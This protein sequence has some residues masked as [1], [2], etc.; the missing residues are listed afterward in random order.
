M[1]NNILFQHTF[2]PT[3]SEGQL[4]A[5][6]PS[7]PGSQQIFPGQGGAT[8][9][10]AIYDPSQFAPPVPFQNQVDPH[11]ARRP[12]T[13]PGPQQ[14]QKCQRLFN[15]R[16]ERDRHLRSYLP[17]W[18][19]CPFPHC[20]WRGDR[21]DIFKRHWGD[22][23]GVEGAVPVRWQFEI[24]SPDEVVEFINLGV[25][26]VD[27]A[28]VYARSLVDARMWELGKKDVWGRDSWG[29]KERKAGTYF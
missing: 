17:H 21:I 2:H 23:H 16:Q 20:P 26:S 8:T 4:V 5:R 14:C 29:R 11:S 24:Y 25:L 18:I 19:Y 13:R 9:G 1:R 28:A 3:V 10:H 27:D 15:R 7:Y 12:R 22:N 6:G